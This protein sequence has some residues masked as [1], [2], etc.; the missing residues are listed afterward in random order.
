[1]RW[2]PSNF[3]TGLQSLF[4]G[5]TGSE[6]VRFQ[7]VLDDVRHAMLVS[8]DESGS[9]GSPMVRSRVTYARDLQDLWYLRG[10][11]MAALAAINGESIA[12][13][14]LVQISDMFKGHLPRGLSS[15]PSPLGD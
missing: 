4:N 15:R 2:I 8:L 10:D 9:V 11:V 14:K 1:M 12:R 13:K 3:V 6:D 7:C 5:L